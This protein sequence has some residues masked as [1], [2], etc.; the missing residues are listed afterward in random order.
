METG[1]RTLVAEKANSILGCIGKRIV[2]RP[3]EVILPIYS[4][5]VRLHLEYYVQFWA[6]QYKDKDLLE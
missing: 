3:W 4:A 5:L 2:R 6:P 1:K